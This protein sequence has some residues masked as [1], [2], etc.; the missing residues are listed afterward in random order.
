MPEHMRGGFGGFGGG[1]WGGGGWRGG[2]GWGGRPMIVRRVGYPMFGGGP[3]LGGLGS[4][5]GFGG[6]LG[7]GGIVSDLL[8]GGIGYLAGKHIAQNQQQ[9]SGQ[10]QQNLPQYQQPVPPYPQYSPQYSQPASP[11][12]APVS[13]GSVGNAQNN[14]LAQLKLL[15]QLRQSGVLTEDEFQRE[16]QKIL[17]GS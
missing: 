6:G 17:N 8:S 9:Q 7:G 2:G 12:Q 10:Y 14:N 4:F 15:G 5:G 11:Y 13:Q 3:G 16:K 1:G